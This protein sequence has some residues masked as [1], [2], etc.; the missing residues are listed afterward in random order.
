MLLM[1][2]EPEENER[3][4]SE[5]V[6]RDRIWTAGSCE[7]EFLEIIDGDTIMSTLFDLGEGGHPE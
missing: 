4:V 2:G 3:L 1:D 5:I 6:G 7:E